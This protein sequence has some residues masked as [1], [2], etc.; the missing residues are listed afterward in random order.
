MNHGTLRALAI[1]AISR[2]RMS[3]PKTA[4]P[5]PDFAAAAK[6]S[7]RVRRAHRNIYENDGKRPQALERV[8]CRLAGFGKD[9]RAPRNLY[10]NSNESSDHWLVGEH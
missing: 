4:M 1:S 9:R 10:E 2:E 8:C 7:V 6:K 3:G 5:I